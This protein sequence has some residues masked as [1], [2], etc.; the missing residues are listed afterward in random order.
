MCVIF[1]CTTFSYQ[2]NGSLRVYKICQ[3]NAEEFVFLLMV[4]PIDVMI[5][6]PWSQCRDAESKM[7]AFT[8]LNTKDIERKN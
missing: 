8:H 5:A 3:S 6:F 2:M 1:F 4:F 7:L